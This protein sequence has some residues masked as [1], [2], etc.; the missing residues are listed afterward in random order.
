MSVKVNIDVTTPLARARR[1]LVETVLMFIL[2]THFTVNFLFY[3]IAGTLFK[4]EWKRLCAEILGKIR[5]FQRIV[6]TPE[7]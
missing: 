4:T 2:Y 6:N 7:T 5:W 3:F 1:D